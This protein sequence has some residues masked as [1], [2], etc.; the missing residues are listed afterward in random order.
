MD[1]QEQ[2]ISLFIEMCE[3]YD[4][5]LWSSTQRFSNNNEP[6]FSDIEIAT[7]YIWGLMSGY[8]QHQQTHEYVCRH[9]LDWFP[10]FPKYSAYVDRVNR[11]DDFLCALT[12]H[13]LGYLPYEMVTRVSRVIDSMPVMLAKANNSYRAKVAREIADQVF[14]PVKKIYYHGV[15]VHAI[16]CS[17]PGTLPLPEVFFITKASTHDLEAF[18]DFSEDIQFGEFIGDKAYCDT[19]LNERMR[20]EQDVALLLPIK[21]KKDSP[22]L[23][24]FQM[25]YNTLVSKV[26]Q[27]IESLFGW[28][29]A[30]TQIE[31]ASKVRSAKG[32]RVHLWGRLA[33]A[34]LTLAR[35]F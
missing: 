19:K 15:K 9:L 24:L 34:M 17:R 5:K 29:Q 14:H 2:L 25:A 20:Q 27:P 7:I 12:Y 30:L 16:A 4:Q 11:L 1:W 32:L 35:I 28:I 13:F 8:Q 18:R 22:P 26:R 21:R 31:N 23:T 10:G 3:M 33:V 6:E